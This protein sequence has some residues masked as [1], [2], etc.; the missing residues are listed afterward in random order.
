M[1]VRRGPKLLFPIPARGRLTAAC[2]LDPL[3]A[4]WLL[5]LALVF[6]HHRRARARRRAISD[7]LRTGG[8]LIRVV[9]SRRGGPGSSAAIIDMLAGMRLTK[10]AAWNMFVACL[11]HAS[12]YARCMA[13][14]VERDASLMRRVAR[15][16][17]QGAT[18][19]SFDAVIKLLLAMRTAISRDR[20]C[21]TATLYR[22]H[23]IHPDGTSNPT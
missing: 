21:S 3:L 20:T 11:F 23:E 14:V 1:A 13:T 7:P 15:P 8:S 10:P 9:S 22:S 17:Y 12:A 18:P 6:F 4:R 5:S 19:G 2:T 16:A